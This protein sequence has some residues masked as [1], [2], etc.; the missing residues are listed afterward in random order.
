M[1]EI[2]VTSEMSNAIKTYRKKMKI[3]GDQLSRDL[4]KNTSFI[5]QLENG[6]IE[7]ININLLY[8]IF[9]KILPDEEDRYKT[10]NSLVKDLQLSLS[11][12]ELE[13]QQWLY[14][15]DLQFRNI[16]IPDS[17]LS[18]ISQ[19]LDV[20]QLDGK[21]LISI[22]NQNRSLYESFSQEQIDSM[23]DNKVYVHLTNT[24]RSMHVKFNLDDNY[25]QDILDKKIIRCNY[26]SLQIILMTLFQLE[27]YSYDKSYELSAQTLFENKFY[28]IMEKQNILQENDIE[29]KLSSYDIDFR[30]LLNELIS[31]LTMIND[32]QP[33]FL[34]DILDSFIQ[35]IKKEPTLAFSI[36]SKDITMLENMSFHNKK[37]FI[38]EYK[39]L[40]IKYS[41]NSTDEHPK[42][43]SI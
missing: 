25:V 40:I 23:E 21:K 43:L 32:R 5:S 26:V 9:E 18:L 27:G 15:F 3:R 14:V 16:P 10:I 36:I 17:I 4:K 34:N 22:I 7:D 1:P 11:S 8:D 35:N 31:L 13:R 20:L 42:I 24:S 19:K 2:K 28:T 38:D 12:K 39:E 29:N 37:N 33:D 41:L 30:K 6:M